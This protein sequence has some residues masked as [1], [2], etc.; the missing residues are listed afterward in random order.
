MLQTAGVAPEIRQSIPGASFFQ[1]I[2]RRIFG[3]IAS[4][5]MFQISFFSPE[6]RRKTYVTQRA[7][8]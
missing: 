6:L 5:N 7:L 4:V 8:F 3:G 2:K 1:S